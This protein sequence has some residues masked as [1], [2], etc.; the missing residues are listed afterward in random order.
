MM[1][2]Y[3][4]IF[5]RKRDAKDTYLVYIPDLDGATEGFGFADAIN[6]ARDYIGCTL[7]DKKEKDFPVPSDI[8]EVDPVKGIFF[9][10]GESIVSM[11]DIDIEV[12]RRELDNKPVRRN[13]SL[14][15]WLNQAANKAH[16]N[17]SRVLQDALISKLEETKMA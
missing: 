12:Y 14:P 10:S 1:T 4:V 3:P 15:S 17:V 7:Y 9:N 6:M 2:A 5:T 11:V 16:I 13:V 8:K